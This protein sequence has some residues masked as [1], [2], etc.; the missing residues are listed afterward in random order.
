MIKRY[1]E[2]LKEEISIRKAIVGGALGA[3]SVL[4]TYAGQP[5][6]SPATVKDTLVGAIDRSHAE[7]VIEF[8]KSIEGERPELFLSTPL[9][10]GTRLAAGQYAG[11]SYLRQKAEDYTGTKGIKLDLNLVTSQPDLFPF[12]INYFYVRGIDN[13]ESATL[14]NILKLEYT[15]AI[16][17]HG[18]EVMFNFTRVQDINTYGVRVNF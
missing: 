14:V 18:H 16:N 8:V 11:V 12:R 10:A 6:A 17:I 4:P 9:V 13:L 3:S 5:P 7:D 1:G 15:A 2:F